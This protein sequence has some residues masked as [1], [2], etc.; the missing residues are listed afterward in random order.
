MFFH[1]HGRTGVELSTEVNIYHLLLPTILSIKLNT[2]HTSKSN[3]L[4]NKPQ[5]YLFHYTVLLYKLITL[6]FDGGGEERGEKMKIF[7]L[8]LLSGMTRTWR[9]HYGQLCDT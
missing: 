8:V 2:I 1:I 9:T 5:Y 3:Q 4:I 6:N 7:K